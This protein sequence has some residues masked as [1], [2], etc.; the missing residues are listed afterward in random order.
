MG[1]Q[2]GQSGNPAG[3]PK[4]A[5][6]LTKAA[7]ERI[8]TDCDPI[9]FLASVMN[10]EPQTYTGDDDKPQTHVPTMD[11]RL[12]AARTLSGKLVPDAKDR[13]IT[14]DVGA[15]ANPK[16]AL[17]AMGRLV[18]RMG[19]GDLTPTEA[20]SVMDV[21]L[22]YLKAWEVEDLEKRIAALEAKA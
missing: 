18:E 5:N 9:G 13:P 7:R 8:A 6:G 12:S 22:I 16:D 20:R 3:R 17:D 15:I 21:V 1:F 11:Q 19:T 4:G 2:P 14:F 10:G